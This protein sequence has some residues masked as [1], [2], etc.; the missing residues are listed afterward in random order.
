MKQNN[1]KLAL[2]PIQY[3]WPAQQVFEFYAQVAQ[4]PVDIVYL[5]ENVCAKRRE[6][7]LRDWLS[8]AEQLTL[9]GKEVVLSTLALLEADSELSQLRNICDNGTYKVE[10]NDMAAIHFLA[11]KSEFIVGPHINSYNVETL[12]LLSDCGAM[13]WVMPVEMSAT[14]LAELL[15][16][17]PAHLETEVF[18]YGRMP[19]SFSARCFTARAHNKDK[20]QC[21]FVCRDDEQGLALSTQEGQR[22]FTING[23]QLQSGVACNL[24]AELAQM[25]TLG[26]DVVRLS[27]Q[28]KGMQVIVQN[29]RDVLDEQSDVIPIVTNTLGM[30]Q[31]ESQWCNGYWHGQPGIDWKELDVS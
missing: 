14:A 10:A 16:V 26:V 18:S 5:G 17:K 20:D 11:N 19:L 23:I 6:I 12:A 30:E 4:W 2:G 31:G 28:S 22:L 3:L 8:I 9:T 29:F 27:P 25:N 13:R 24:L 1:M 7:N 21:E 15:K